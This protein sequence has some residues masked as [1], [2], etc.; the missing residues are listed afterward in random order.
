MN[1]KKKTEMWTVVGAAVM[2]AALLAVAAFAQGA[3]FRFFGPLSRIIT[4]NGDAGKNNG[5]AIFCFDNPAGSGVSGNI[6][7][8]LG[9][10]VATMGPETAN[11]AGSACPAGSPG[12]LGANGEYMTWDGRSNGAVVHSGI[13]VYRVTAEQKSYTGTIIVVR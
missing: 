1:S 12:P 3:S 8:L 11:P 9:S 2:I 4:P 5:T 7:S 13:Y 10:A 6:F